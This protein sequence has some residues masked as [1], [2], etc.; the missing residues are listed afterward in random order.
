MKPNLTLL[1]DFYELT[2][3]QGYYKNKTNETV[4]FDAF[5]R[6]NPS[7]S[8]YAICAGLEQVI[9]YIKGLHFDYEDI[10]YLR[11]LKIFDE[12]FL[13]YL[14]GFHF[15][16]DIYAIPE[17]TVVFPME[18]LVKVVA[19]IMEAQLVETAILNIINHQSL[20]AT[21][22]SRVCYAAR[23]E[24]VMEFGLRRAQGPDA[25][26]LGARAAVIGGCIGTSNVLCAKDYDIPALGTHA[27][28]WIM[29]FEDELTAFRKYAELYPNNTT[30]LVD[31]YDT[32]RS[33]VPHAIQVFTELRRD[34]KM[35]A[36]YGIRLDSGDLAY[37]S[38]KARKMLDA[39][40]FPDAGI[41][42]SSDLDEYLIDSLKTQGAA[43]D[44]W[45]V[46]TNLITSKDCPSFG[47]VYKLAAIERD[48]IFIPKIKLSENQWKI[49]NP[50]NKTVYRIYDKE[51]GKIKADL[52]ALVEE[53]YDDSNPLL[54]FDPVS[55]WKKTY[56]QAKAYTIREIL[57][58][59]F[60]NG[61]CV[62]KS[63]SVMDIRT[64]C[65]KELDTLWDETR[66][67]VNPHDVYVDLSNELY[68]I[69]H[70]L[71]DN[72]NSASHNQ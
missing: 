38:K 68:H 27:H 65:Q 35:P 22:A 10:C 2:M 30:L 64:Y 41:C 25:G 51:S 4:V 69:K 16:G 37:L 47:G 67:L 34:G 6:T 40:G 53:K 63:P 21:K 19:P 36:K 29:S 28:S 58:P 71:L 23:G 18:P 12:D 14:A 49:T 56:L 60:K 15:T 50:G 24:G 8:G 57:V 13:D 54:L 59:I 55:T 5:Y 9:E 62:Y 26:T 11:S 70:T 31:T 39:A 46:G 48:G 32:L 33:G 1:T 3:M 20:I 42:A 52:I 44:S 17:G 45:G 43:I 7:G 61:Q 66:R 72:M